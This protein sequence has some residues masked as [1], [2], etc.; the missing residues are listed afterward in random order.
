MREVGQNKSDP[1]QKGCMTGGARAGVGEGR[2]RGGKEGR[3]DG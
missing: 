1:G 3:R 2:S